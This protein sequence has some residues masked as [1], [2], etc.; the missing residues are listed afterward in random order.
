MQ[1]RRRGTTELLLPSIHRRAIATKALRKNR[2]VLTGRTSGRLLPNRQAG[3]SVNGAQS[4]YWPI[5][6]V[7]LLAHGP[8]TVRASRRESLGQWCILERLTWGSVRHK[9]TATV[10]PAKEPQPMRIL[11]NTESR[12]EARSGLD[13]L[14]KHGQGKS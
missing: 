1:T 2:C 4:A 9:G 11:K 3:Q 10:R 7:L 12:S 14:E 5:K 6:R 13:A 8:I